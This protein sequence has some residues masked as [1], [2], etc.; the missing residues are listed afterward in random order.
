MKAIRPM[1]EPLR[2][3]HLLIIFLLFLSATVPM[4][5]LFPHFFTHIPG[6][7]MDTAEYPLN[8]WWT[9]H[10]LLDLKTNPFQTDYQFYPL[11][12]NLVQ[13]TYTFLDGLLYAMVR[14]FVSLIVFHNLVIWMTLAANALAAYCLMYY[15]TKT[16]WL[17]FIG[18]LAF[19]HC[20][21]LA[22][23]YKT[24]GLL[25]VYALTFFVFF[26]FLAIGEKRFRWTVPAGLAWG[27]SLYNYPYYFVFG[28]IWF[29]LLL[30]YQLCPWEIEGTPAQKESPFQRMA[31]WI[32]LT[33][34]LLVLIF[35]PRRIWEWLIRWNLLNWWT[36]SGVTFFL[37]L[38]RMS[39]RLQ[40][41]RGKSPDPS[42]SS[43]EGGG[44]GWGWRNQF[45]RDF[46]LVKNFL[47]VGWN[48]LP[49]REALLLLGY[50]VLIFVIA[51]LVGF[52]YFSAFLKDPST[53]A[54]VG[55]LPSDFAAFSVDL[56]SFFAPFN[57]WLD[58]L[59]SQV[60]FD[61]LKGR[62]I[63]GTPAFLGYG[64][65]AILV[66]GMRQFSGRPEW[67]LWLIGW[68]IFFLFCLGP[69]L[70]VHG[71]I[72]DSLPLPAYLVRYVPVLES[73]RTLSRYL[74]PT[75]LI[76]C[77]LVCLILNPLIVG[78][79][80]GRRKIILGGLFLLVGFEYGLLPYANPM[81]LTNYQA[82]QVYE[83]LARKAEGRAGVLLNLPLLLHSGS[84]TEGR[85]ETRQ[86]YYQTAHKQKMLGGVSSKLDESIPVFFRQL[87]AVA[88][89]LSLRPVE[90]EELAGL[91]YAY[92]IDWIVLDKRYYQPEVLKAY[93]GLFRA[94]AY[95]KPFF[96]DGRYLGLEVEPK[97][98][99]L[100]ARALIYWT[101]NESL[102]ALVYPPF[103]R[104]LNVYPPLPL[105]LIIPTK[106]WNDLEI[107]FPEETVRI[108]NG[109]VLAVGDHQRKEVSFPASGIEGKYSGF[110]L[111]LGEVIP[112]AP[113]SPPTV[114]LMITPSKKRD[115]TRTGGSPFPFS[116]ISLGQA[117]GF[118]Q[119]PGQA[120]FAGQHY[121]IRQRGVTAFR[122]SDQGKVREK[123]CFD[124]HASSGESQ[125]L[126][127]WLDHFPDKAYLALVVYDDASRSL[128]PE[129]SE[130]LFRE[131]GAKEPLKQGDWRH[132]YVLLSKKGA[133]KNEVREAHTIAKPAFIHSEGQAV[134][135]SGLRLKLP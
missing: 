14:P 77:L 42:P 54:A 53:R 12:Q 85:G 1:A 129:V 66:L 32:I 40:A 47:P 119:S 126:K 18:A 93:L 102:Q 56:V 15:L 27:L 75:M 13:H 131:F 95:L 134:R 55:S 29:M 23:Y 92:E 125:A 60:A 4:I 21:T 96:E 57:V 19:A 46:A 116:V 80:Q 127:L 105:E 82:P 52:P 9:A 33:G 114:R 48:P 90:V 45:Q 73:A 44:K 7:V 37:I 84:F 87:P 79:R 50:S 113:H 109:L 35:A 118:S 133:L 24:A 124:T 117:S 72:I 25:E 62:P 28:G 39:F 101:R 63:V 106:L 11:G 64:F 2:R 128:G 10:A 6:D 81:K 97:S 71:L 76:L 130:T 110:G 17:A 78:S 100:K 115:K 86:L 20:P 68:A 3:T 16:P 38:I 121:F 120:L 36:L 30:G 34:I 8:E 65:L 26:S 98:P 89:I 135:I 31:F 112:L 123:K 91:I 83:V 51:A 43:S 94:S 41:L 108:F 104:P 122:L 67:R 74:V 99:E 88:D 107:Q 22:S 70:K 61:W 111:K 49:F 58:G 103:T 59:Y 132:S 5:P 69:F